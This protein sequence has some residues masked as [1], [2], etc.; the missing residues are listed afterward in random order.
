MRV[1]C[2]WCQAEGKPAFLTEREPLDDPT[3]T[4]GVCP[5]HAVRLLAQLRGEEPRPPADVSVPVERRDRMEEPELG[6]LQARVSRWAE[7]GQ[8]LLGRVIPEMLDQ[9]DHLRGRAEAAELDAER[10]RQENSA[11]RDEL[12]VLRSENA[13]LRN[14]QVEVATA[15][16]RLID[17]I[18]QAMAPFNEM[19]EGLMKNQR[20]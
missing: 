12:I 6:S 14:R 1:Y 2:A 16:S 5:A 3:I 17:Q 20:G 19:L 10:L 11:L 13:Q 8:Y 7:E 15:F 9:H 18:V 4:H